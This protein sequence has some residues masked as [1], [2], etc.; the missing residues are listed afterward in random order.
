MSG[1]NQCNDD[2][3][4]EREQA[5]E[6][7]NPERI[8]AMSDQDS[9][10]SGSD[11]PNPYDAWVQHPAIGVSPESFNQ[12]NSA[13]DSGY[14]SDSGQWKFD[15]VDP[16]KKP[17][18]ISP[19]PIYP[20]DTPPPLPPWIWQDLPKTRDDTPEWKKWQ[21][22]V[23]DWC[24]KNH[25]DPGPILDMAKDKLNEKRTDDPNDDGVQPDHKDNKGGPP[26]NDESDTVSP[27][28]KNNKPPPA[29]DSD[30][31]VPAPVQQPGDYNV[32][33]GDSANA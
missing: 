13:A 27:P 26:I 14:S 24:E 22:A 1:L 20:P 23:K 21:E 15:P 28:I 2:L 17:L 11:Q 29:D 19:P 30:I 12:D 5:D 3:D 6:H 33:D 32:P 9:Q 7:R 31:P 8:E 16:S 10:Q 18:P 4:P 25:V